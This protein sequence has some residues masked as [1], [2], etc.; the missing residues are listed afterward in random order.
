MANYKSITKKHEGKRLLVKK[1]Y[2]SYEDPKEVG[3]FEISPSGSYVKLQFIR[4][5]NTS[6]TKW[7]EH[8]EYDV[9]E[10]LPSKAEQIS[11][12]VEKF[13]KDLKEK[14]EKAKKEFNKLS[15]IP[16]KPVD[17]PPYEIGKDSIKP[18]PYKTGDFFESQPS[19]ICSTDPNEY[20]LETTSCC[21]DNSEVKKQKWVHGMCNPPT[22]EALKEKISA[23]KLFGWGKHDK[24]DDY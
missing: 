12:I 14:E 11:D 15:T 13:N 6:Y 19:S 22:K 10:V 9:L 4:N 18:Y 17:F 1:A 8:D 7:C 16:Y 21:Q 2:S 5:D 20:G 3:V 23:A 24:L